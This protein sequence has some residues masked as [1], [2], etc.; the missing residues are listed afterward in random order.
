MDSK[1]TQYFM[2]DLSQAKHQ[3]QRVT[4]FQ[5]CLI[6]LTTIASID[7]RYGDKQHKK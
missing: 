7:N 5:D 1:Y 3:T 6:W 4:N 2:I